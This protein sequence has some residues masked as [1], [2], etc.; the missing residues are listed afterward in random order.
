MFAHSSCCE[1]PK[2]TKF[3]NSRTKINW[4]CLWRYY[5][6][7][8]KATQIG[9]EKK[10]KTPK[11]NQRGVEEAERTSANRLVTQPHP[12]RPSRLSNQL[13]RSLG[14]QS[15]RR[16]GAS[17]HSFPSYIFCT[18]S[19]YLLLSFSILRFHRQHTKTSTK[20]RFRFNS[21][22]CISDIL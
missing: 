19:F 3:N 20:L 14:S 13:T 9:K 15:N 2:T 6:R 10:K 8:R 17:T 11:S 22:N 18:S 16:T 12:L 4:V 21:S 1:E 7:E 5:V